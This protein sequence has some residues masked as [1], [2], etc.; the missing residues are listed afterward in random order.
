[1]VVKCYTQ[2]KVKLEIEINREI[3]RLENFITSCLHRFSPISLR[4]LSYVTKPNFS[5][6]VAVAPFR[7]TDQSLRSSQD[8]RIAV[9]LYRQTFV[10]E[11]CQKS[12]MLQEW[13]R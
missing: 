7:A 6:I 3:D 12:L 5:T 11:N 1:M 4:Y 2:L 10:M 8:D 9:D 13:G